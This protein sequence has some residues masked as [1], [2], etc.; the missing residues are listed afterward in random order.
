MAILRRTRKVKHE[1]RRPQAVTGDFELHYE[2]IVNRN[3]FALVALFA[4]GLVLLAV[5]I[6]SAMYRS[7]A[8][9]ERVSIEAEQGLI[10]NPEY[11]TRVDGDVTASGNSYM[12]FRIDSAGE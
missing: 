10:I 11:V 4:S 7:V 6:P 12:E 5:F 1:K 2:E 8:G 9:P 3:R